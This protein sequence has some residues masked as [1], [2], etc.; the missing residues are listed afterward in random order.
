MKV[1]GPHGL[2]DG[3][4][5]TEWH[6]ALEDIL[7]EIDYRPIR[8]FD[9]VA[10]QPPHHRPENQLD[11]L[12]FR[13]LIID[14]FPDDATDFTFA[15]YCEIESP[16]AKVGLVVHP[17][18]DVVKD[19]EVTE[20]AGELGSDMCV[21]PAEEAIPS[22]QEHPVAHIRIQSR[23]AARR[24]S[25]RGVLDKFEIGIHELREIVNAASG[26]HCHFR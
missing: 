8:F 20:I 17:R 25:R 2:E 23:L 13:A 26:I 16:F 18:L 6:V 9:E 7:H 5:L 12:H 15:R 24:I 11:I 14:D 1:S 19:Q 22:N 4:P 21:E 3:L 10:A